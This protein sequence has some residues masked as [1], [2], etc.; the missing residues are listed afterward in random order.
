MVGR[1]P[2][3]ASS[4]GSGYSAGSESSSMSPH[5]IDADVDDEVLMRQQQQTRDDQ[6]E[7]DGAMARQ[8]RLLRRQQTSP[9]IRTSYPAGTLGADAERLARLRDARIDDWAREMETR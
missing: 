2:G 5:S 3:S 6:L 7:V 8:R 4:A 1:R 9:G